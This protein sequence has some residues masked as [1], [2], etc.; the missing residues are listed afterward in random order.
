MAFR[1]GL[2]LLLLVTILVTIAC[3]DAAAVKRE[4]PENEQ[5][6]M[7]PMDLKD[8]PSFREFQKLHKRFDWN[9][10]RQYMMLT[11]YGKRK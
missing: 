10:L 2:L 3:L 5:G 1:V 8:L 6:E 11:G 4:Y 7:M 9:E